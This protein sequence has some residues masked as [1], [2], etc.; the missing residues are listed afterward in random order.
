[1]TTLTGLRDLTVAALKLR[2]QLIGLGRPEDFRCSL[3]GP[4][5]GW[6]SATPFVVS[7]TSSN[8]AARKTRSPVT[9][10]RV[11]QWQRRRGGLRRKKDPLA[12][13]GLAGRPHFAA[14]VLA[15]E[16]DRWL[17]RQTPLANAEPPAY[18]FGE[19]VGRGDTLRPLP[20]RR[21][22]WKPS[23]DGARRPTAVFR[24]EFE[25]AVAG[26][27]CLGYASH[28]GLGLFLPAE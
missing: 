12:C 28:F 16:M 13:H 21:A 23:D 18:T 24:V 4:A 19:S 10:S 6:E 5:R 22:R 20:F 26:P 1:M 11:S 2:V 25:R 17:R 15:E 27:L 9:V 7:G 8:A 3:F 14:R